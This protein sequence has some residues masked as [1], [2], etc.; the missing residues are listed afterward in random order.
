MFRWLKR[1]FLLIFLVSLPLLAKFYYAEP[2]EREQ[3]LALLHQLLN[4][5]QAE[6]IV[7]VG[8][9]IEQVAREQIG[10]RFRQGVEG[11]EQIAGCGKTETLAVEDEAAP[12]IYRWKDAN[13]QVHFS[14]KEPGALANSEQK[15]VHYP[16]RKRYFT[17]K[18]NEEQG[19]LPGPMRD[20]IRADMR[21][22][23]GI[24]ARD[25]QLDH[26][27]QVTLNIRVIEDQQAFQDYRAQVAPQVS[28]QSGFYTSKLNEAVV[29]RHPLDEQ[30]M[31]VVRHEASHVIVAGLYG[32][33]PVWFNEGL[34]EYFESMQLQGQL[35]QMPPVAYHLSHLRQLKAQGALRD[36]RSYTQ[37]TPE[38]WYAG[39]L[40]DHYAQA[41]ALVHFLLSDDQGKALL[42]GMMGELAQNYCWQFNSQD[43]I[44]AEYPGGF[45]ALEQA[46]DEWLA[47]APA[48]HRY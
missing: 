42:R 9:R 34:A 10:A 20:R 40:D 27:R 4:Q 33:S 3:I 48:T 37:L 45:A 47:G 1:L 11:F 30:M 39:P 22:I 16:Q 7:A 2:A 35:R 23:Y 24:L 38:Q 12:K 17:L 41:W 13:G 14:D 15:S 44:E 8:T 46:W 6:S 29:F 19:V 31:A 28:T 43:Y 25:M 5:P 36:L 32:Y 26:L 21:Q 18:L